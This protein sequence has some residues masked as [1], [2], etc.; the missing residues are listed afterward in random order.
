MSLVCLTLRTPR[1]LMDE[2]LFGSV[3]NTIKPMSDTD[4]VV[5]MRVAAKCRDDGRRYGKNGQNCSSNC[6]M[7]DPFEKH[8]FQDAEGY[9][10]C[11]LRYSIV[12]SFRRVGHQEAEVFNP[13]H[14]LRTPESEDMSWSA[15]E[16]IYDLFINQRYAEC[17][18][19]DTMSNGSISPDLSDMW[20]HGYTVSPQWEGELELDAASDSDSTFGAMIHDRR[21]S[22]SIIRECSLWILIRDSLCPPD[23]IRLHTAVRGWNNVQFYGEFAALWFF[24]MTKNEAKPTL[25]RFPNGPACDLIIVITSVLPHCDGVWEAARNQYPWLCRGMNVIRYR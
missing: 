18:S 22:I 7:A 9:K 16:R 14:D 23:V 8:W 2:V 11:T 25:T 13:S 12:E 3:W 24:L 4:D 21:D 17:H 10:L 20:H 19:S 15:E 1:L 5:R 6:Y